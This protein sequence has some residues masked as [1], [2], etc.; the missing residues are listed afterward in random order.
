MCGLNDNSTRHTRTEP[1][2]LQQVERLL[3][4]Q[5]HVRDPL[6]VQRTWSTSWQR[7]R[8][9]STCSSGSLVGR[10]L[11]CLAK[12]R[13][14]TSGCVS[15][16]APS[17]GKARQGSLPTPVQ[18]STQEATHTALYHEPP[19]LLRP[20]TQQARKQIDTV[21]QRMEALNPYPSP[22]RCPEA[23][24]LVSPLLLGEW[25]LVY[26]SNGTV[27]TRTAAAQL[28]LQAA[29]LPGVGLDDITQVRRGA[30]GWGP[31]A[32]GTCPSHPHSPA[33]TLAPH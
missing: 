9:S 32:G 16:E 11:F 7:R 19:S 15:V 23:G 27:V 29:Q 18:N 33:P 13:Y 1:G 22:L 28:L 5:S 24:G 6:D 2:S 14:V 25:Q 30:A 4:T 21:L 8:K 20:L 26:A 12:P 10:M 3:L 17:A 31:A